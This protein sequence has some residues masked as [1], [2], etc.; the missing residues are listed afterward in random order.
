[1]RHFWLWLRGYVQVRLSGRQVNRF[2][3]LCS[4]NG[5]SLW[6]ISYDL[7]RM[8]RAHV[9][10]RDFYYLK[11]YLKKTK[12]HLRIIN[13]KGFPFWCHKHPRLKWMLLVMLCSFCLFL[14]SFS[15]VW[16]IQISGNSKVSTYELLDYLEMQE[17]IVGKKKDTI[18]CSAIEYMLREEFQQL[19]WVSVYLDHTRLCVEIKESLYDEFKDFPIEDGRAYHLIANKDA[20]I[21][22]IVTRSGA[23]L[24]EEGAIVKE[25]DVLVLGECE[26]FDDAG[27]IKEILKVHAEALIYGDVTYIFH[28]PITEMEIIALRIAGVYNEKMLTTLANQKMYHYIE[29]LEE[30]GVIILDKN[31]MIDKKKKNIVFVGE[32]KARE[33]IGI[34]IPVEEVRENEFE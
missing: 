17:I 26:I 25:N 14:Y 18:D 6:R 3:N 19:G 2:L 30:N 29:K 33:Q 16:E 28:E 11:P 15:F 23:P 34:N 1:M 10:L 21:Y 8:V 31:V 22:S 24:V 27:E 4:R 20:K 13:R 32:I 7:E 9:R 12:T 5:I